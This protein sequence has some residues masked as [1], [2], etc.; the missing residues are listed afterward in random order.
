MKL[1][2]AL[3]VLAFFAAAAWLIGKVEAPAPLGCQTHMCDPNF[4]CIS[5]MGVAV[6]CNDEGGIA[7]GQA[8]ILGYCDGGSDSG[9][10]PCTIPGYTTSVTT[11][12]TLGG[13]TE[14]VWDTSS[15][16]GRW[17]DY[18]G[19]QTYIISFPPG[20]AGHLP[21]GAPAPL[22]SADNPDAGPHQ[23]FI[24]GP[25]YLVEFSNVT[26]Y[27]MTVHNATCAHYSLLIE[28]RA[29]VP[30]DGGAV[31]DAG[32]TPDATNVGDATA[33][34]ADAGSAE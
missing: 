5:P 16:D 4:V 1:V 13:G 25:A 2:K 22:V 12:P 24:A 15:L 27:Q 7:A 14:I 21:T 8:P 26:P 18:P 20:L 29:D 31:V 11:L 9:S 10:S 3:W 6:E 33:D 28:V 34:S 32:S 19:N 23:N 17:L 30:P